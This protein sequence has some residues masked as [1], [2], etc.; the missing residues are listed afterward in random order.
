MGRPKWTNRLTVEDCPCCL[1]AR[2]YQRSRTFECP[3]GTTG[4]TTWAHSGG[5]TLGKIE[6]R[7]VEGGPTGLALHLPRQYAHVPQFTLIESQLISITSTRPHL[8]GKR[9]WFLCACGKRVGKLYI[10]PGEESFRCRHCC[11]LT[12]ESAQTHDPRANSLAVDLAALQG[13]LKTGNPVR[14]RLGLKAVD[15]VL[16]RFAKGRGSHLPKT[17]LRKLSLK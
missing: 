7:V 6:Y 3:L 8:G 13:A 15:L 1:C 12:Y 17:P 16:R 2:S 5:A 4:I 11:N 9:F 10:P 14:L